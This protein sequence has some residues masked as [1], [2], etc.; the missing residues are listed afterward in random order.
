MRARFIISWIAGG[1]VFASPV[2]AQI[3]VD[4]SKITCDQFTT[5]AVADPRDIAIWLSG[6][7]H[8]KTNS[9][10]LES[11]KFKENYEKLKSACFNPENRHLPVLQ[12][13]EMLFGKNK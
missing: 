1:L 11:Q 5:F 12:V 3:T 8:G 9:P 4:V 13:V 6:Y 2:Q 10:I 7:Y